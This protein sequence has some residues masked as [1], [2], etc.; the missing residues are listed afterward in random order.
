MDHFVSILGGFTLS[1]IAVISTIAILLHV[2]W[3]R[4]ATSLGPTLLTTFGIF[5]CFAGIAWGLLDFNPNDIK[6]SVP[7][8]LQGIRT[9]FWASVF[10]IG[11]ALTIKVRVMVQGAPAL[12][13]MGKADGATIDDLA[14]QLNRLN[15][16][17][18]GKED[19][20]LLTQVKL[21]R[22]DSNDHLDRLNNSFDRFAEK[23]AEANSKA[24]IQALSEVI[25]DFN[26][27]LNEQFGENFK[28]LNAAVEKLVIWQVQYKSSLDD[29]IVQETTTRKSMTDASLRYADLVNRSAVFTT[30]AESLDRLLTAT[31]AQSERL[32][33]SLRSLAELVTVAATGLPQIEVKIV[34]MTNQIAQGVRANQDTLGA[35]LKTSA[36]SVQTHS[37]ELTT[38]LKT[39]LE[40]AN[41]EL[42]SHIRQATEDTKKQIIALDK[43]LEEELTKS[44]ETLGRQLTAL[45]QQFVRDYTP[46]TLKLQQLVKAAAA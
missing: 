37:Q 2:R 28:Q 41:K 3:N 4:A 5:F 30:T 46:L 18:A 34:E 9:S 12:S 33:T 15:R 11:W 43:A 17:I 20:T 1:S 14:E 23:M 13:A 39:T 21:L 6:G 7:L 10:G 31:T 27:K 32:N 35:V 45:S 29:L 24:L 42:N 40:T 8:L 19:S 25:K 36:Q 44:I 26:E 38:L 22:T 16:S